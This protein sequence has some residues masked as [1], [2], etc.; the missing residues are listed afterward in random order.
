MTNVLNVIQP[1]WHED[2]WVFDDASEGLEKEPLE[3]RFEGELGDLMELEQAVFGGGITR[4]IDYLVKD[5]PNAREGFLLLLSSQPFAGYQVELTR[6]K[7]ELRGWTYEA[8]NYRVKPWFPPVMSRYFQVAP[9]SLYVRAEPRLA[10]YDRIRE[11]M[12][13]RDRVERLEQL[14]GKLTL[15]N[16]LLK[17]GKAT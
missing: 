1:Y 2:A 10:K 11:V 3:G 4:M 17:K 5:I 9:E 13:L 12:A 8:K 7:K 14:V 6:L 16:D 15:E